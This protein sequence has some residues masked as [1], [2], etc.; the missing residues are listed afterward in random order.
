M[1][2]SFDTELAIVGIVLS[3]IGTIVTTVVAVYAIRDARNLVKK[4]TELQRNISYLRLRN[5]LMWMFVDPTED[6]YPSEIAKGFHDFDVLAKALNP[7]VK[8]EHLKEA[9]ENE[10]LQSAADLVAAGT[11]VWK[12]EIDV[13]EVNKR[14]AKWKADKSKVKVARLLGVDEL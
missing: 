3:I 4:G 13:E 9:A 10:A 14:L 7:K 1:A 5:D 6:T 8:S 2:V 11:F 12:Q